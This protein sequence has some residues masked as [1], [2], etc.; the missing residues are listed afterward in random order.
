MQRYKDRQNDLFRIADSQQG[1]FT[2]KQAA[3]IGLSPTNLSYHVKAGNWI[4]YAR[5]I[6]R[7]ANYPDS[8]S[9]DLV[10][11]SLWSSNRRQVPQGVYSHETAAQLH[12]LADV[13]P[14]KF[15][16]TVPPTFRRTAPAPDE[17]ILHR[18]KLQ[19]G[20]VQTMP[21]FT[22]TRPLRTIEDLLNAG[23]VSRDLLRDGLERGL[24]R[25]MITVREA[26]RSSITAL[27][28]LLRT[29]G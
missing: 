5:G 18:A 25:G 11:W 27:Q 7:L 26:Q 29:I 23:T 6:Y 14:T 24:R 4:R 20:D 2:L 8:P 16:M 17:L 3:E 13:L 28:E 9:A 19:P 21:G 15:H 1:F 10:V 12:E 22:V